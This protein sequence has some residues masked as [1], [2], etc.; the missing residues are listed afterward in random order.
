MAFGAS[1]TGVV[2][3]PAGWER[4]LKDPYAS[5]K[6]AW[7]HYVLILALLVAAAA[8]WRGGILAQW[9]EQIRH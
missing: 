7:K 2:E 3:L 1:L 8:L 5:R 9:W 6:K 4:G